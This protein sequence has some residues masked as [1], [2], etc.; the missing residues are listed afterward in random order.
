M[1]IYLI[2]FLWGSW[3][4]QSEN[5]ICDPTSSNGRTISCNGRGVCRDIEKN[6]YYVCVCD[7]WYL[8]EYCEI[9]QK[10]RLTAFLLELGL[11]YFFGAGNLYLGRILVGIIKISL[12]IIMVILIFYRNPKTETEKR[13]ILFIVSMVVIN[14]ILFTWW[15]LDMIYIGADYY[16]DQSEGNP[17]WLYDDFSIKKRI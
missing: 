15:I 10:S 11:G 16:K 17:V 9:H 2:L 1:L 7:D 13:K 8:G 3:A 14:L 12:T 6:G 4:I 5:G